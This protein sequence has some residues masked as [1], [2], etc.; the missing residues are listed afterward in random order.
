MSLWGS[1]LTH[2]GRLTFKWTHYFP[3]YEQHLARFVNRPAV[4][5][6]I[7]V[8]E[9]GSLQLW[10]QY[11][12]AHVQ[13]VGLDIVDKRHFAEDQIAVRLGDQADTRFLQQVLEEFGPPDAVIDDG[14]HIMS[15]VVATF[16]Y[17][18]PRI[19]P[20]GVYI[21]EDLHTAYWPKYEG[22]LRAPGSFIE[23]AK[24]LVD[25]LNAE[26][27]NGQVAPTN[28]TRST[29]SI[30]FYDSMVVFERGRHVNKRALQMGSAG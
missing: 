22:G 30:H 3:V 10:K 25:E 23:L 17:L 11:F 29:L 2:Q 13:V 9:G 18:Y 4:V 21:V 5:W 7:G 16:R 1:F 19:S 24:D 27:T 20:T 15:D 12:G 6:E 26:M 28:F 14:S 8:G